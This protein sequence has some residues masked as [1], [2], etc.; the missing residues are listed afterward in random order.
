[1]GTVCAALWWVFL[2]IPVSPLSLSAILHPAPDLYT[3]V[4]LILCPYAKAARPCSVSSHTRA[5]CEGTQWHKAARCAWPK[6]A[7]GPDMTCYDSLKHPINAQ[8][9]PPYIHAH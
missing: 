4:F 5:H 9:F 3:L 1:M 7:V 8:D 2:C 6:R